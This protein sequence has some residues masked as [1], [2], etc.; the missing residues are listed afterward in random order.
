MSTDIMITAGTVGMAAVSGSLVALVGQGQPSTRM[1]AG[2]I[3]GGTFTNAA[4]DGVLVGL[5]CSLP[6][7]PFNIS[8]LLF[9]KA[10]IQ[11]RAQFSNFG[12]FDDNWNIYCKF[13]QPTWPLRSRASLP[14]C[15]W[16]TLI[17][18][19]TASKKCAIASAP[20]QTLAVQVR[21]VMCNVTVGVGW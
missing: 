14:A 10:N 15:I 12:D 21:G 5:S 17:G 7:Q 20:V 16:V 9:R 4:R 1:A 18:T 13:W 3:F 2:E 8:V 19:P 11:Y 6:V